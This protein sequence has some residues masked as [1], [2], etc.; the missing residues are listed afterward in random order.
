MNFLADHK[1]V[2]LPVEF[3]TPAHDE[4]V[5][6]R[7]EVLRKPLGLEFSQE[8]MALECED[9]HLACYDKFN[10]LLGCIVLSAVDEETIEMKQIAVIAKRQKK[11]IGSLL[12]RASELLSKQKKYK[13]IVLKARAKAVPF[14]NGLEYIKRGKAFTEVSLKHYKMY[15]KLK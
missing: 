14:Y 15:K 1:Y 6:L 10:R 7:D 11:G 3:A 5:R 4:T 9:L 13:E 8:E 12:V 2:V